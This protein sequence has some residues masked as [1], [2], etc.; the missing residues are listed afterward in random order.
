MKT[1]RESAHSGELRVDLGLTRPE[2]EASKHCAKT[3]S[4]ESALEALNQILIPIL[5]EKGSLTMENA[6]SHALRE[7]LDRNKSP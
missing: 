4:R 1:K 3:R 7:L 6:D 2:A 5:S